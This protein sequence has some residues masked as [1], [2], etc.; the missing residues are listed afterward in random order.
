VTQEAIARGRE[1]GLDEP[2]V[3]LHSLAPPDGTT[4]FVDQMVGSATPGI[5]VRTFTWGAAL[6]GDHDVIHLHWPELLLRG[7]SPWHRFAKR[8]AMR[9]LLARASLRGIPIVRTLHNTDPHEDGPLAER[10]L[11]AKI[12]RRTDH[13][14]RLNPATVVPSGASAS[15]VLHGHYRD[16]FAEH[17]HAARVAGRI[18]YFGIIRRYKGVDTLIEAFERMRPSETTLRIVGS[19]SPDLRSEVEEAAARNPDITARLA[20][21]DDDELVAEVTAADLVVLPY[22]EMHNSG[23]LLVALSLGQRVLVPRS[24]S[25][26][27]IAAEVGPGWVLQYDGDF[28]DDALGVGIRA[29]RSGPPVGEPDLSGRDWAT[30]GVQLE[31][32]YRSLRPGGDR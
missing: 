29:M 32:L 24:P 20:F 30:I 11:L 8:Q 19:P 12:D 25:N 28:D 10:R 9:L 27:A 16:R 23:V 14:I 26:T 5:D 7:R 4:K 17:P 13:F 31:A 2:V 15:T 21:V 22:R 18:L 3:V 6:R 1:A